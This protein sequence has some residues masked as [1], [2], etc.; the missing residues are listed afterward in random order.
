VPKSTDDLISFKQAPGN[1]SDYFL[2]RVDITEGLSQLFRYRLI[3]HTRKAPPDGKSW[4]EVWIGQPV[5]ISIATA[6]EK[7]RQ[8]SGQVK[9]FE[10]VHADGGHVEFIIDVVPALF[11][12]QLS[13]NSR[14]F[15]KM[16]ALEI[17]KKVLKDYPG[18]VIFEKLKL[19]PPFT[20]RE[21][22]LQYRETDFDFVTRLMEEE[23][24][25][26]YFRFD[27][28]AGRFKHKLVL[29]NHAQ[30][31]I[32]GLPKTL[33]YRKSNV[34]QTIKDLTVNVSSLTGKRTTRAYDYLV[35]DKNLEV[36][37]PSKYKWA[38]K[39]TENYDYPNWYTDTAE[40]KRRST[41]YM[42]GKE[43]W[44]V[45]M[46]GTT[47]YT[48]IIAG[49]SH[50]VSEEQF[51]V[52]YKK[53]VMIS[54][55]HS[56]YDP[57]ND[58]GEPASHHCSFTAIPSSTVFRPQ[59]TTPKPVIPGTQRA[60][61]V[62]PQGDEIYTDEHGRIKVQFMWDR[63][64]KKDEKSSCWIRVMQQW[65]GPGYGAQWIPRIGMEVLVSFLEGDPDQPIVIGTV[66][67][68]ANKVPLELTARKTQ[69]GW[70]T[71]SSKGGGTR[72]ELLFEDD[73][74][75]EEIYMYTGR[76]HRL[77]VDKDE[78]NKIGGDQQTGIGGNQ[79]LKVEKD[80]D[81]KVTG[82][83]K[84]VVEGDTHL[85]TTGDIQWSAG[86]GQ[87]TYGMSNG[88]MNIKAA[89]GIN[90]EVSGNII[91]ITPAGITLKGTLINSIASGINTIMGT[92]VMINSGGGGGGSASTSAQQAK[93]AT[94]LDK[95]ADRKAK[96]ASGGWTKPREL[97]SNAAAPAA[98]KSGLGDDVDK[99]AANS[100]T[101]QKQLA[102]L[103]KDGWKIQYGPAGGGSTANRDTKTITIDG[104]QKGDAS[105]SVQSLA[106]EAG[107]AKY[108]YVADESSRDKYVKGALA[109]EG[110][111]TL[112]NIKVQRE[113]KDAT[114]G[115]SDIGIAGNP[116]N[117]KDYNAAYDQFQKDGDEAKARDTIGG[118]F[119]QGEETS[120]TH[121]KYEDYYG[122]DYDARHPPK[123]P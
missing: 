16:D 60:A 64:G 19:D 84:M 117:Q 69:S 67:N 75:K 118:I 10:I 43:A 36:V 9:G 28:A 56:F 51:K 116:A 97:G 71:V 104:N 17:I 41:M 58:T 122:S 39:G 96:G 40:G 109:D 77:V 3:G 48:E 119:G 25:F 24:I 95:L 90:L 103:Q 30:A 49:G 120:N 98:V 50:E 63:D 88:V 82:N 111:A 115:K 72:Q 93:A 6:S 65:A 11:T 42:E 53:I 44:S 112:N 13:R 55:T 59:R 87:V 54:V 38:D 35:P 31:Y 70:R 22:C 105:A 32:E 14:M 114:G 57:T 92:M 62:G 86:S 21:Y 23:G 5:V 113:I 45:L 81:I 91:A 94:V 101:L 108:P 74:G 46:H 66:Y 4:A 7:T 100:P 121:Q 83:N 18:I 68:G 37:T 85:K 102:E 61:V 123:K 34:D 80:R 76:N 15:Q 47:N 73:A 2:L 78:S 79:L 20:K 99:L 107:H 33:N 8:L 1:P 106:H 110:A 89:V 27:E 26:F 12:T 52:L 29:A